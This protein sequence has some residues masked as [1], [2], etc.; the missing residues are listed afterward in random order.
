MT[1]ELYQCQYEKATKCAM[2]LPCLGCE[3]HA[4]YAT[5]EKELGPISHEL[6]ISVTSLEWRREIHFDQ[7]SCY[8]QEAIAGRALIKSE[9]VADTD[10]NI[11]FAGIHAV[12]VNGVWYEPSQIHHAMSHNELWEKLK[13]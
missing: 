10:I 5:V 8:P 7:I 3:T 11:N 6:N 4:K 9:I 13:K 1:P 12:S 2:D